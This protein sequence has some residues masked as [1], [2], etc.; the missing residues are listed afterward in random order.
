MWPTASAAAASSIAV[1][2][3]AD[4]K[5]YSALQLVDPVSGGA[6][7]F[8]GTG[9]APRCASLDCCVR[10][11]LVCCDGP[12]RAPP[13]RRRSNEVRSDRLERAS[14]GFNRNSRRSP[15][16]GKR[17]W[18]ASGSCA[19]SVGRRDDVR[20]HGAARGSVRGSIPYET[21]APSPGGCSGTPQ[22]CTAISFALA[23][24]AREVL[25]Y[26][27]FERPEPQRYLQL[28]PEQVRRRVTFVVDRG[29]N[30]PPN[31]RPVDLL[32]STPRM[33]RPTRSA[34]LRPGGRRSAKGRG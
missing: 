15:V 25:S 7:P 22:G 24:P 26:D 4:N 32:L 13:C 30:G 9:A 18:R 3:T 19:L 14:P 23:D 21:P 10:Q 11:P 34:R 17:Y 5:S 27:P 33:S 8:A 28:V 31:D 1:P 20:R 2:V 12:A 29:D 16:I 6:Q